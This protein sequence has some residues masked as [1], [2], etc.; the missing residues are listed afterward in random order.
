MKKDL[1]KK[2]DSQS[3]LDVFDR[4][5]SVFQEFDNLFGRFSSLFDNTFSIKAFEDMQPRTAFPKVNVVDNEDSYDVEVAVA[6]F[7]KED[8]SL[9]LKDNT[10]FINAEKKE[11]KCDDKDCK[12]YLRREIAY[13]SFKRALP[14]PVE[15]NPEG[16]SAKYEN[17]VIKCRINKVLAEVPASVKIEITE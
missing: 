5:G 16:I 11:E 7:D 13:R 17:G 12:K 15:I 3:G 9:E 14:F 10:L 8:V 2:T 4:F 6:G 1:I